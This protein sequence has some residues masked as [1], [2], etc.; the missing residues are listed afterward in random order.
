MPE[1]LTLGVHHVGLAVPDIET[2]ERFFVEVLGW[3]VVGGRPSY[4][5]VF[6]S[7][8]STRLTLWRVADPETAN[9]FDR[10]GNVGLHHLALKVADRTV[11]GAVFERVQAHPG[12]NVEFEPEPVHEGSQTHHFICSMPGGVRIEFATA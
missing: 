3:S 2:A 8:G 12:V 7:D 1:P 5:A 11:L 10:R 6:V 4:P 9:P